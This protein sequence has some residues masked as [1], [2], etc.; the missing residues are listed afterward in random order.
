MCLSAVAE[1]T[2]M[3]PPSACFLLFVSNLGSVAGKAARR[4]GK[5]FRAAAS[6]NVCVRRSI[7]PGSSSNN[8]TRERARAPP[9]R[10]PQRRHWENGVK[11]QH[12]FDPHS[13][14]Y[15]SPA[16]IAAVTARTARAQSADASARATASPDH[17]RRDLFQLGAK[18]KV[19]ARRW[20]GSA[21]RAVLPVF[22]VNEALF[23]TTRIAPYISSLTGIRRLAFEHLIRTTQGEFTNRTGSQLEVR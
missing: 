9:R 7:R 18:P 10:S 11:R 22:N 13:L 23:M 1:Q 17:K 21:R 16:R 6:L 20:N 12:G 5:V 4:R 19:P 8:C 3:V 14:K 15:T 2:L